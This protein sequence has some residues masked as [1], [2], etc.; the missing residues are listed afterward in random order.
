MWLDLTFP[1]VDGLEVPQRIK[2]DPRIR[3]M[4]GVILPSS[5]EE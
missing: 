1:N 2:I 5:L 3:T 4:P